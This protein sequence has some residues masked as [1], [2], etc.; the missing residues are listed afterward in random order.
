M[1]AR[2]RTR[3]MRYTLSGTDRLWLGGQYY[4]YTRTATNCGRQWTCDDEVGDYSQD[5][6]L[7]ITKTTKYVPVLNGQ[8]WYNGRV[9][10]EFVNCPI[11]Y[12]VGPVLPTA[13]LPATPGSQ[14]LATYAARAAAST[15]PSKPSVISLPTFLG[16]A[17]E[18]PS[19][20][21][22]IPKQL[23]SWG[24]FF[25]PTKGKRWIPD[26]AGGIADANLA[27]RFGWK[28]LLGDLEKLLNFQKAVFQRLELLRKLQRGRKIRRKMRL[29]QQAWSST[30][31][32]KTTQSWLITTTHRE[33]TIAIGSPWI[34]IR[35]ALDPG[36]SIPETGSA[37]YWRAFR[38][39]LGL[40]PH[41]LF[42]A[43]WEL[44]PW[45]WLID[46]FWNIG[47]WLQAIN[48]SLP[49]HV[50]SCCWCRTS[51]SDVRLDP[52]TRP[53]SWCTLTGEY[54]SNCTVKQRIAINPI[55]CYLPSLPSLPALTWGQWSIL[56]SLWIQRERRRLPKPQQRSL[57]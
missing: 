5:N 17:R 43:A 38:S 23:R 6:P 46:W 13:Y 52:V 25:H 9:D 57:S 50:E 36:A 22:D 19:Q 55:L 10:K 49:L 8:Y 21:R 42:S 44:L 34:S 32:V 56:G 3:D 30:P 12:S 26:V 47:S 33:V 45:S 18:L 11:T 7:T 31:S 53:P 20:L 28:P 14:E 24:N 35:W 27:W 40:T 48:H 41:E 51:H 16:E 1:T 39:A 54:G 37:L 2:H 4:T 15:N 29:P